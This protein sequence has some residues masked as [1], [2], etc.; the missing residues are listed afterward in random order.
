MTARFADLWIE[1]DSEGIFDLVID[2]DVKDFKTTDGLDSSIVVSLFSDRRAYADEVS[3][4]MKR[5][6]WIGDLVAD[7]SGDRHGS[8]LWL[9]EQHRIVGEAVTGI[10]N[11][12]R[13]AFAWAQDDGLIKTAEAE[14]IA[15]TAQRR[16]Y[17]NITLNLISGGQTSRAF[18]LAGATQDRALFDLGR[19]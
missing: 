12:A 15:A 11:E 16:V 13:Q 14:I 17:L 6:G 5:R 4:P 1:Q 2:D 8:G 19:V 18:V 3:D 10:K 7:T 9:Y